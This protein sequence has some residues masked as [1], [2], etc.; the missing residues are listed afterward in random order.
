[1][2]IGLERVAESGGPTVL[3]NDSVVERLP[4]LRSHNTVVSR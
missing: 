1:M 2:T 3:P 4:G